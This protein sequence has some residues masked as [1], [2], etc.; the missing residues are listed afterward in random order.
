MNAAH[1]YKHVK[2]FTP[3]AVSTFEKGSAVAED[4]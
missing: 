4:L 2:L 1:L 3:Y